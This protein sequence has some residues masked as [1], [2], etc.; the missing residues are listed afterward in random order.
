MTS[1][2]LL[3]QLVQSN[4]ID[5]ILITYQAILLAIETLVTAVNLTMA[6]KDISLAS[7]SK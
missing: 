6:S 1:M 7:Y 3:D 4:Y 5:F 2:L